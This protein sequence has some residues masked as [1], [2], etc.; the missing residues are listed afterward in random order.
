MNP[1]EE[2]L[3]E[4]EAEIEEREA[5]EYYLRIAAMIAAKRARSQVAR[6]D[7]GSDEGAE[8]QENW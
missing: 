6:E 2:A 8:I 7:K 1:I 4:P 3:S 5:E